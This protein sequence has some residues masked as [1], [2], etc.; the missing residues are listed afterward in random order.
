LEVP[1]REGYL[2]SLQYLLEEGADPDGG[3]GCHPIFLAAQEGQAEAISLLAKYDANLEMGCDYRDTDFF[4]REVPGG[5]GSVAVYDMGTPLLVALT[6]TDAT[7]V[8][9]LIKAGANVNATCRK[10]RY[11]SQRK[12]TWRESENLTKAEL[13]GRFETVYNMSHWTPLLEAVESGQSDLVELLLMAGADKSKVAGP[14][15]T[16][17]SLAEELGDTAIIALLR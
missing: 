17:M 2:E 3:E 4:H 8:A 1:A 11:V 10:V 16:A 15:M 9:A 6:E 13:S 5:K 7:A 14:G 12:T